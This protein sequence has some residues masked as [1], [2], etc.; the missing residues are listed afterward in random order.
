MLKI[1]K[2]KNTLESILEGFE[3]TINDLNTFID[4]KAYEEADLLLE[5]S[6]IE[7]KIDSVAKDISKAERV[8]ENIENIIK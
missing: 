8:V 3:R 1:K 6:K 4:Q 2:S 5:K 7:S